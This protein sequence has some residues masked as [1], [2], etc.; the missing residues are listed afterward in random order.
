MHLS[1][2]QAHVVRHL[3]GALRS[4]SQR[5]LSSL[6]ASQRANRAAAIA[7]LEA[8]RDAGK[9]PQNR[10]F[11]GEYVSYFVDPVTDAHCAVGHLMA[12]TGHQALV[13]RIAADDNH[14]RVLDLADDPEV[15]AWLDEY[16][17]TLD[18][19]AG[20]QPAYEWEPGPGGGIYEPMND[21]PLTNET[22]LKATAGVSL[23]LFALQRFTPFG[24]K[25]AALPAMNIVLGFVGMGLAA[26]APGSEPAAW[27]GAA[28][29]TSAAA[30]V[31]G[32]S[33]VQ[34]N[35]TS[36]LQVSVQ[37]GWDARQVQARVR[38]RF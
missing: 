31:S 6:T 13:R 22:A 33:G 8:Y 5:E 28:L 29:A 30:F 32:I 25:A 34:G 35:S 27:R 7:L 1:P 11:A 37:P 17:I 16:G 10:D 4:L 36:R 23:G 38:W 3:N 24:R 2:A 18:E 20:I 14:V 21:N 12:Q 19:A 9:Y 15:A 26:A